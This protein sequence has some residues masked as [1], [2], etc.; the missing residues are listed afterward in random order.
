VNSHTLSQAF[1][2]GVPLHLHCVFSKTNIDTVF[3]TLEFIL[4]SQLIFPLMCFQEPVQGTILHC[5]ILPLLEL[6]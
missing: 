2:K 6:S 4:I 5:F 1:I 3:W